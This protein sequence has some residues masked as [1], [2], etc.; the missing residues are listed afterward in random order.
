MAFHITCN[1]GEIKGPQIVSMCVCIY[2]YKDCTS[3]K[4]MDYTHHTRIQSL[5]SADLH[6]AEGSLILLRQ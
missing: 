2:I 1:L 5:L 3:F 4:L 6:S